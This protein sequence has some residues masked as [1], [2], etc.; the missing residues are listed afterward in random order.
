[1]GKNKIKNII[2]C[3][4]RADYMR[5][6]D[7]DQIIDN[8]PAASIVSANGVVETS[9]SKG[10]PVGYKVPRGPVAEGT[11]GDA[12]GVMKAIEVLNS[13]AYKYIYGLL[14]LVVFHPSVRVYLSFF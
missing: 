5:D 10:F 8:L 13:L 11:H 4:C 1:L 9:Y 7:D 2:V 3:L 6:D 14:I 12:G